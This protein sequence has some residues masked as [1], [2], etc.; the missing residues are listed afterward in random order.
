MN[1]TTLQIL[2]MKHVVG[3]VCQFPLPQARAIEA[4]FPGH[5]GTRT[6]IF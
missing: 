1:I 5:L 2:T 3:Y 4:T 6:C